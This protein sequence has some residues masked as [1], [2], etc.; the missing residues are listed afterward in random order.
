VHLA[1]AFQIGVDLAIQFAAEI[2]FGDRWFHV[3]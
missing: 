1:A 2:G 3:T